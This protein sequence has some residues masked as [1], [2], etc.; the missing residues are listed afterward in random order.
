MTT[1]DEID[2]ERFI[3]AQYGIY[4][5]AL[6]ELEAGRKRS[7]WMWFVF[8]QFLGLGASHMSRTYAIRSVAEAAAYLADPTLGPRLLRCT[9]AMLSVKGKSAHEILGYPDDL[10]FHSCM[11]LFAAVSSRGSVFHIAL[12]HFFE[13]SPDRKTMVLLSSGA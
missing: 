8:P 2:L 12:E 10:K 4:E 3:S 7:H 9:Q 13:G 1:D 11:T 6:A 5:Q